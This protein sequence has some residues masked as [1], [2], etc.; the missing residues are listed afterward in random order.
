[1]KGLQ[2]KVADAKLVYETIDKYI[3]LLEELKELALSLK[4]DIRGLEEEVEKAKGLGG[5]K[6]EDGSI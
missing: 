5:E 2:E 4:N 3:G 1:M 6:K